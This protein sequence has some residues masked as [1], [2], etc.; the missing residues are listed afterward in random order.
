M[1]RDATGLKLRCAR[2]DGGWI[3]SRYDAIALMLEP[4]QEGQARLI[5]ERMLVAHP[6]GLSRGGLLTFK[7]PGERQQATPVDQIRG[8]VEMLFLVPGRRAAAFRRQVALVFV[9]Y[10]GGDLRLLDEVERASHV[11]RHLREQSAD[12][13]MLAFG[14]ALLGL[15]Q[16][17]VLK[18]RQEEAAEPEPTARSQPSALQ[19]ERASLR[20]LATASGL[21]GRALKRRCFVAGALLLDLLHREHPERTQ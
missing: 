2:V 21:E 20:D 19:D 8:I 7:F 5:W 14:E 15:Q 11:Q 13:P 6:E 17:V 16:K 12:H 3:F 1:G 10:V 4:G 18:R 9:R